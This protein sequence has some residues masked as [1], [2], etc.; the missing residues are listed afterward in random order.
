MKADLV[1]S[2][3][4]I[5]QMMLIDAAKTG[6]AVNIAFPIQMHG[7]RMKKPYYMYWVYGG[8]RDEFSSDTDSPLNQYVRWIEKQK[9]KIDDLYLKDI[10]PD[11][12]QS[13]INPLEIFQYRNQLPYFNYINEVIDK[14]RPLY[15]DYKVERRVVNNEVR[16][17]E[18]KAKMKQDPEERD[19]IRAKYSLIKKKYRLLCHQVEP[20][21]SI[22]ATAVVELTYRQEDNYDFA[23]DVCYE[24]M[25]YNALENKLDLRTVLYDLGRINTKENNAGIAEV[26]DNKMTI[27]QVE[28]KQERNKFPR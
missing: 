7:K 25:R 28:V 11:Y 4:K 23:W 8:K 20:N 1:V 12:Y 18:N 9:D 24:G 3:N 16:D 6:E 17:F 5:Y 15:K 19:I 22:L 10:D 27:K 21:L 2:I 13:I 26:K 14:L